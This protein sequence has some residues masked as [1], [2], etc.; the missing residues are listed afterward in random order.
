MAHPEA[1]ALLL[2][3]LAL[4]SAACSVRASLPPGFED[5][6]YC[7]AGYCLRDRERPDGWVGPR[8][9]FHECFEEESGDTAEPRAWGEQEGADG[10]VAL[11]QA[12]HTRW[13]CGEP[14]PRMP[15]FNP[16][17][18]DSEWPKA[19]MAIFLGIFFAPQWMT[20]PLGRIKRM[21]GL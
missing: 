14:K 21:L 12:G 10:R 5:E 20:L 9:S 4:A 3:A 2:L 6:L 18:E 19:E 17:G 13:V 15:M 8:S 7:R 1:S 11:L 16:L